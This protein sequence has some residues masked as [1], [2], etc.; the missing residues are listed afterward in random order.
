M[1]VYS[2]G[3]QIQEIANEL[4]DSGVEKEL[5]IEVIEQ[6]KHKLHSRFDD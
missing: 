4:L 5:V 6:I 3:M 1:S 2:I